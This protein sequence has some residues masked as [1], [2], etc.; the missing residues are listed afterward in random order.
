MNDLVG[1][2]DAVIFAKKLYAALAAGQSVD[3]SFRQ[4]VNALIV[5]TIGNPSVPEISS[6]KG[7]DLS[8]LKLP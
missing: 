5:S 6:M 2:N 4:A 3:N 8:K 1:D 7:V